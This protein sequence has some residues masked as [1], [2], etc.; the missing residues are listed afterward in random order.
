M[1]SAL[2]QVLLGPMPQLLADIIAKALEGA[3]VE[4]LD[5]GSR[6]EAL[7]RPGPDETPPAVVVTCD[8][9][10]RREFEQAALRTRPEAT[11]LRVRGDARTLQSAALEPRLTE[12]GELTVR[13]IEQAIT[14]APS[15]EARLAD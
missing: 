9:E 10:G 2:P 8:E 5:Q 15:W 12:L 13:L 14:E 7:R 4:L 11:I 3:P 1:S 6:P